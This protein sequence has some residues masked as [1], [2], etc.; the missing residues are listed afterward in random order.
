[1]TIKYVDLFC[2]IGGFRLAAD[3]LSQDFGGLMPV[4]SSDFD[5][6][7]E[8]FY[9]HSFGSEELFIND[10]NDIKTDSTF[11]MQ[12]HL[13]ELPDFD[14]LL[15]GFPC[16]PFANIGHRLGLDDPRGTLIFKICD[17]LRSYQP[18]MFLL[19][20]VQKLRNLGKGETL[21]MIVN[22]LELAGYHTHILDLCAS[23]FGVPQQRRRIF[24]CGI[25]KDSGKKKILP[26][27]Q[28]IS[29]S[30][31]NYPT[32]WHL[33]ERD[34][35]EDHII[36]SQTRKTVLRRNIKWQGDIR[37]D[38]AISRPITATMAKWHRANQDNYFSERYI[39]GGEPNSDH[40]RD[41]CENDVIRRISPL[42]GFRLQGF[43]DHFE[44]LRVKLGCR[45][46]ATYRLIGNAVPVPLAKAAMANL[47]QG[48]A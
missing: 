18:K 26:S 39:F 47:L 17:I 43:P 16:Q 21:A 37:I 11:P 30:D 45:Y 31:S 42:E 6:L 36:P 28:S 2:G 27:L 25:R 15:A 9:K 10:V 40:S 46:T 35:D 12:D 20:N 3:L 48:Y 29:L 41:A 24:F 23:D 32:T 38:R 8:K 19:E 1:M 7:C 34:M 14:L 5:P 13:V 33:L 4:A 22:E 44:K